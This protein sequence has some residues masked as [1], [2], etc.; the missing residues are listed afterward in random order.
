MH[1]KVDEED[2]LSEDE[3]FPEIEPIKPRKQLTITSKSYQK[4]PTT[5]TNLIAVP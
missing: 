3:E 1:Q 4:S 5:R 2:I